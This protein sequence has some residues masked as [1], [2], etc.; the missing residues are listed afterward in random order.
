MIGITIIKEDPNKTEAITIMIIEDLK[1]DNQITINKIEIIII[2]IMKNSFIT[3]NFSIHKIIEEMIQD[4]II[5][6][7]E[8]EEM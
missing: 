1:Q 6:I 7:L 2:E 4:T 8:G 3:Q 5:Q